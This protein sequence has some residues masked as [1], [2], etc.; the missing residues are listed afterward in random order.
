MKEIKVMVPETTKAFV[1][2]ALISQPD[3]TLNMAT[4]AVSTE[5]VLSEKTVD[6]TKEEP[7]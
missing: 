2:T 6:F 4:R 5:E 1:I 7:K 3:G